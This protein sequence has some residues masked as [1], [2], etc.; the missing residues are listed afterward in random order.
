MEKNLY[1]ESRLKV[2]H[3]Q[4]KNEFTEGDI[5]SVEAQKE[6][7]GI[8]QTCIEISKKLTHLRKTTNLQD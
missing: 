8:A 3:A 4:I 5:S 6:L 7:L 1:L 2:Y